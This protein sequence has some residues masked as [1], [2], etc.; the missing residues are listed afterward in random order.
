M[1]TKPSLLIITLVTLLFASCVNEYEVN[2]GDPPI[3]TTFINVNRTDIDTFIIRKFKAADNYQTLLDTFKV[4][5]G[6]PVYYNTSNDTTSISV[7]DGIH[8]IR[9]G[10]DWQIFIPATNKT[11]LVSDFVS[12]K[13]TGKCRHGIFGKPGCGCY[14]RVYSAK[15]NNQVINFP[16]TNFYTI[17]I[18]N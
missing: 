1:I 10:F 18:R 15:M 13:R 17:Y 7:G 5:E 12:E 6:W 4:T 16:D 3:A 14:N 11:V 2:C 9:L 8:G